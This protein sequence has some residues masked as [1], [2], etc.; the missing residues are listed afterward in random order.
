MAMSNFFISAKKVEVST[1]TSLGIGDKLNLIFL[2]ERN[3]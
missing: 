2:L 1:E 3:C